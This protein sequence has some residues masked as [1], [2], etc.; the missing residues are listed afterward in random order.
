ME[1]GKS[2]HVVV[3]TAALETKTLIKY[4]NKIIQKWKFKKATGLSFANLACAKISLQT[5][6]YQFW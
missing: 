1:T 3:H 5:W 4:I 6:I 2:E